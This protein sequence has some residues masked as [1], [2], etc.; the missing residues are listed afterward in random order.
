MS[1]EFEVSQSVFDELFKIKN[2]GV[3]STLAKGLEIQTA[4]GSLRVLREAANDAPA[5]YQAQYFLGWALSRAGQYESLAPLQS[6]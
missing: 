3:G 5:N 2:S 1:G 6:R 4:K